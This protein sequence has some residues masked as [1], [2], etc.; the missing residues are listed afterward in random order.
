MGGA[1]CLAHAAVDRREGE[2]D[3]CTAYMRHESDTM[4]H[5]QYVCCECVCSCRIYTAEGTAQS[6]VYCNPESEWHKQLVPECAGVS[7]RLVRN[8]PMIYS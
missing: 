8:C 4:P 1:Q 5:V 6:C 7:D 3:A 2:T